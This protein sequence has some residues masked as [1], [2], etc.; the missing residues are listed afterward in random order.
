VIVVPH[1]RCGTGKGIG[2]ALSFSDGNAVR[3]AT[4]RASVS[5]GTR[6]GGVAE[7][8]CIRPSTHFRVA[9][10]LV[11]YP[12]ALCQPAIRALETHDHAQIL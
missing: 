1:L 4:R 2:M 9:V 3:R 12:V 7:V 6:R 11:E 5:Q 8:P 10:A